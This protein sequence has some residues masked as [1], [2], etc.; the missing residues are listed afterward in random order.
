MTLGHEG[1]VSLSE[2]V[3]GKI[4]RPQGQRTLSPLCGKDFQK[5]LV[6]PPSDLALSLDAVV[7]GVTLEETDGE[8]TKPGEVVGH[9]AIARA[10]LILVE[11]HIEDPVQAILNAPMTSNCPGSA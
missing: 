6:V 5:E 11:G 8:A 9:V 4:L 1:G 2:W 10:A 3:M 7:G